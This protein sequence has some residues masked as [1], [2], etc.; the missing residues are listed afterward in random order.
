VS[1]QTSKS[2]ITLYAIAN[3]KDKN[4]I[5]VNILTH[6]EYYR[7]QALV[8]EGQREILAVFGINWNN[9][10]D[11]EDMSIVCVAVFA[12]QSPLPV[13][14]LIIIVA[15]TIRIVQYI[16][17]KSRDKDVGANILTMDKLLICWEECR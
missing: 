12:Q 3:M 4:S 2:P 1:G 13:G 15:I 8:E 10:N 9:F 6:L 14:N 16:K 5:N 11:S 7:I 17:R